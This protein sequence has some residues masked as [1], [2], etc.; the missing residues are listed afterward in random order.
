MDDIDKLLRW[1]WLRLCTSDKVNHST[2]RNVEDRLAEVGVWFGIDP[3]SSFAERASVTQENYPIKRF[4]Y[5][6]YWEEEKFYV[7]RL[8][9][10]F[11]E[12]L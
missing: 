3:V 11:E 10:D 4:L 7:N 6:R 8:T 5:P 2:M 1:A 9:P 12:A